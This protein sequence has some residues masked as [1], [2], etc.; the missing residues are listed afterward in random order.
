MSGKVFYTALAAL[1]FIH[2]YFA[3]A[4]QQA[5]IFK[6]G[7]LS[8]IP[9]SGQGGARQAISRELETL[10]YVAG[11][12]IVFES[13]NADNKLDRLAGLADELVG[14]KV[15]LLVASSSP[16]ALAARNATRTIPIVFLGG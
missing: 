3:E 4:Q 16:A 8:A 13:R 6:I 14:L 15:D 11:K 2:V 12:N 5:K 7:Y 1:L 9:D 10:G